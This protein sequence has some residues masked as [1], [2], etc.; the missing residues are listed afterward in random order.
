MFA[1]VCTDAFF[2]LGSW[3][4]VRTDTC[5]RLACCLQLCKLEDGSAV[6]HEDLMHAPEW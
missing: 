3:I 4:R 5:V 1:D 2:C 6:L